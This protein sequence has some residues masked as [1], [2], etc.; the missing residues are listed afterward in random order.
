MGITLG[1]RKQDDRLCVHGK[2]AHEYTQSSLFRRSRDVL[3]ISRSF[4]AHAALIKPHPALEPEACLLLHRM[5]EHGSS[6]VEDVLKMIDM[7]SEAFTQSNQLGELPIHIE[8]RYLCRSAIIL[9]CIELN[10][11]SLA[12]ADDEGWLPLHRLLENESSSIEDALIMI[13]SYPAALSI[14]NKYG[15]L[16]IH[17]ECSYRCRSAVLSKCIEGCPESLAVADED[18]YLPLHTLLLNKSSCYEDALLMIE[19]YPA[20]LEHQNSRGDFPIHIE[21]LN[22]CRSVVISKCLELYPESF[23]QGRAIAHIP[24]HVLLGNESSSLDDA[25]SMIDKSPSILRHPNKYGYL[26]I[27]IECGQQSR[28][29]IISACIEKYPDSLAVADGEGKLP[30]HILL[31]NSQSNEADALQLIDKYPFALKQLSW[32]G[33]IKNYLPIHIESENRCRPVILLKC[34]ELYP[35]SLD[36]IL[37]SSILQRVNQTTFR[38]YSDILLRIFIAR[39][40]SLYQRALSAEDLACDSLN[41]RMDPTCRRKILNLLPQYAFASTHVADYCDLNWQ[42]RSAMV[43]LLLQIQNQS[44]N[45]WSAN[46]SNQSQNQVLDGGFDEPIAE[47]RRYLLLRVAQTSSLMNGMEDRSNRICQQEDMGDMF[48]RSIVAFL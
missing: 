31:Q 8:C 11:Q 24:L 45:G 41:R 7:S 20:A 1:K 47:K 44:R 3:N 27:H 25:L 30:L 38:A 28:S 4:S 18:E 23:D 29:A 46:L 48:L 26:P 33:W 19:R 14:P 15:F 34:I 32:H 9:K 2:F 5:L 6:S 40:M 36:E 21:C 16:P 42:S 12:S 43:L 10:P 37:I 13:N 39:P 35:E 22:Q 17:I